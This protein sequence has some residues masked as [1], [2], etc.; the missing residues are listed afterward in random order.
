MCTKTSPPESW[1]C[2][3]R[4]CSSQGLS[5]PLLRTLHKR[6]QTN[7][8][9]SLPTGQEK[10]LP[11][12][13]LT[14]PCAGVLCLWGTSGPW[15]SQPSGVATNRDPANTVQAPPC[16]AWPICAHL[17][18][19][20]SPWYPRLGQFSPSRLS[21]PLSGST[22]SCGLGPSAIPSGAPLQASGHP[23]R[24]WEAWWPQT[25]ATFTAQARNPNT[26]PSRPP[27]P[28]GY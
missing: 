23:A 28:M 8:D 19:P 9:F 15:R 14:S 16:P 22:W 26:G 20:R 4:M 17:V 10:V 11:K 12:R 1:S 5:E 2:H 3:S 13:G 18:Y 27:P 25:P 6:L 7:L 21:N 24:G